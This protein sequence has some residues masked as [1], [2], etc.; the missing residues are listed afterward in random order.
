MR[1]YK[2]IEAFRSRIG[3]VDF[4]KA[5]VSLD[6]RLRDCPHEAG[7]FLTTE[8]TDDMENGKWKMENGKWKMENGKWKMEKLLRIESCTCNP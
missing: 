7:R 2:N 6:C 1:C 3:S 5:V 8:Y 4:E